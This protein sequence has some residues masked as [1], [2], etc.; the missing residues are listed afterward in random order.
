MA[1][2]KYKLININLDVIYNYGDDKN[3]LKQVKYNP[4]DYKGF[5]LTKAHELA[6]YVITKGT[7]ITSIYSNCGILSKL[8]KFAIEKYGVNEVVAP[9]DKIR[10][11]FENVGF[12]T[13]QIL[14][15]ERMLMKLDGEIIR[16]NDYEGLTVKRQ[17]MGTQGFL[18]YF[19]K[20]HDLAGTLSLNTETKTILEIAPSY[21][22]DTEEY[23]DIL[24]KY[25]SEMK[26]CD[27][28]RVLFTNKETVE[29]LQNFGF[30]IAAKVKNAKGKFYDMVL[31]DKEEFETPQEI[32]S[33]LKDN[34]EPC[35]FTT[36]INPVELEK[37]KIGSSHDIANFI[38]NKLSDFDI[39]R[40][41]VGEKK[42]VYAKTA[43]FTWYKKDDKYYYIDT[44][45]LMNKGPFANYDEMKEKIAEDWKYINK[46]NELIIKPFVAK[47]AIG[48]DLAKYLKC[49][50]EQ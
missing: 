4:T 44:I 18:F 38:L 27:K 9:S 42:T 30:E 31:M 11:V 22:Y 50:K 32:V 34:V 36:L 12:K 19:Y 49:V 29:W 6:G 45:K 20:D 2:E 13:I 41:F 8:A 7:K 37:N 33:W 3:H 47:P 26:D 39:K 46:D 23:F 14:N 28:I 16:K 1:K 40:I 48:S 5:V 43:T 25:A 21:P 24:L 10:K 15:G 35:E 17:N